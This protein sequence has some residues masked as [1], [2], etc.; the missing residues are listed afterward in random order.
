[1]K[2]KTFFVLVLSEITEKVFNRTRKSYVKNMRATYVHTF[3]EF[4]DNI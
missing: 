4:A 2:S 3:R 1:M